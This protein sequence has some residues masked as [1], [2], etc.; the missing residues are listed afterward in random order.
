MNRAVGM[1]EQEVRTMRYPARSR[2]PGG[3]GTVGTPLSFA[4]G[5]LT[6]PLAPR[7][8]LQGRDP[9]RTETPMAR[10]IYLARGRRPV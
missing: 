4:W 2:N 9:H 7:L 1:N 5:P 8:V 10:R 6:W 3:E